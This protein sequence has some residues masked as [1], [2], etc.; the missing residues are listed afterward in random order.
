MRARFGLNGGCRGSIGGD[1]ARRLTPGMMGVG[2]GVVVVVAVIA[3]D[4][5]RRVEVTAFSGPAM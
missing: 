2:D 1:A 3:L 5:T 4:A